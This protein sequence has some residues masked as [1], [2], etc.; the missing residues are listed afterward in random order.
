MAIPLDVDALKAAI[1]DVPDFPEAGDR[2][3]GHHHPA[4]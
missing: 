1:R 3:Q 4:A 2:L